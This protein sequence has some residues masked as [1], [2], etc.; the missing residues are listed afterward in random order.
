VLAEFANCVKYKLPIR[1]VVIL[2]LHGV[3]T[4][5]RCCRREI[6][7][8]M[9]SARQIRTGDQPLEE[10]RLHTLQQ[11]TFN[12][13][14][15]ETNSENG[16]LADNTLKA[17]DPA[18]IAGVGMALTTYLVGIERGFV[19]RAGA[20]ERTLTTLRFFWESRQSDDADATGYRG[21]YYHFLDMNTGRRAWKCEL[22]TVD[23]AILLAGALSAA[24]YFNRNVPAEYEVR[25]LA[26]RL[27]ARADWQWAQN[28]GV[29]V[30]HGWTPE[31]GFLPYV[32]DGYCEG[33]LLYVLG[34][35]APTS[36]LPRE[37]FDAWTSTY[38]WMKRTAT[39][40]CM[41][42]RYSCTN[43]RISGSIFAEFRMRTCEPSASITSRTAAVPRTCN[44]LT[45][46]K[47]RKD[48]WITENMLGVLPRATVPGRLHDE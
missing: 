32:W 41:A 25:D 42:A 29:K 1:V 40:S 20:L 43:C 6:G 27:Y 30:S 48:S 46:S 37:S 35:G 16:L 44:G 19:D 47:T 17:G 36:R 18:S 8:L 23:T 10:G 39:S 31:R 4:W 5:P 13:F 11:E 21:F 15:S 12:Y 24:E 7:V 34:L 9:L 33:L 28:N 45:P 3:P 26:K 38:R 14:W 22:S 2:T